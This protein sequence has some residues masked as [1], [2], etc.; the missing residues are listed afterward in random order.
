MTYL[1][2]RERVEK[3]I[4]RLFERQEKITQQSV[5]NET[6]LSRGTI[7]NQWRHYKQKVKQLNSQLP[8]HQ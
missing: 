2:S 1:R 5:T 6:G 8:T 4:A 7:G 3:A